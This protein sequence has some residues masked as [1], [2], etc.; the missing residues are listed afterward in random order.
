MRQLT[1]RSK[2]VN[3]V[4]ALPLVGIGVLSMYLG[5]WQGALACFALAAF[6]FWLWPTITGNLQA[7]LSEKAMEVAATISESKKASARELEPEV[8]TAVTART[9]EFSDGVDDYDALERAT[10]AAMGRSV[11]ERVAAP[12]LPSYATPA[13][14][15]AA[16]SESRDPAT[17]SEFVEILADGDGLPT[18]RNARAGLG[19][20]FPLA[21]GEP[22]F[23]ALVAYQE[24]LG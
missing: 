3:S 10:Y 16:W 22:E 9:D 24:S 8:A 18:G 14:A 20:D 2:I 4:L 19:A 15:Y 13:S 23:E 12:E 7:S 5:S 6:L 11:P 17:L 21:L 1:R